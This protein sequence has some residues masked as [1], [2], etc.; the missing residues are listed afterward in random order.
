MF[1]GTLSPFKGLAESER[2]RMGESTRNS[3]EICHSFVGKRQSAVARIGGG[4]RGTC[5]STLVRMLSPLLSQT[6]L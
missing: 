1:N 3:V 2:E 4:K 6:K 5:D